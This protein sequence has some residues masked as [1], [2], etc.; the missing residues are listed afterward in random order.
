MWLQ[1]IRN[2]N[3]RSERHKEKNGGASDSVVQDFSRVGDLSTDL[4]SQILQVRDLST[5]LLSQILQVR[6]LSTDLLSQIL[7]VR[8]LS[9]NLLSQ[10]LQVR[11]PLHHP[12]VPDS[13][14]EGISP[15]TCCPRFY[16]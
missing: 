10:I 7:Q 4:L 1:S 5:D 11:G 12:A 16:R 8:D 13:T 3:L 6:D 2:N 14:G 15:L 9:T